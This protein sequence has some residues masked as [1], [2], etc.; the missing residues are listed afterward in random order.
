[1]HA[2]AF[3]WT[4]TLGTGLLDP[5]TMG[6]TALIPAAGVTPAQLP[7]L[8]KRHDATIFAAA[9]GVYRQMLR[10]VVPDLPKLRHGLS[11]GEKLPE[12]THDRWFKATQTKIYEA[13]GMSECSTFVS[14]SPSYPAEI[15]SLG[16]PQTGRRVA[17]LDGLIAKLDAPGILAVS[18]QDPGLMLGYWDKNSQVPIPIQGDWFET[19][20]TMQMA[21]DGSLTYLG[22]SDDMMNAGG[23]RVSP[24]EVE[25]IMS[26]H[27]DI[28]ECAAVEER[29][30]D[31]TSLIA[32]H[33]VANAP[34]SERD[35]K[36]FASKKLGRYKCPRLFYHC[37]SLPRGGNGKLQR[38]ALRLA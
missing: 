16:R 17:V 11:A 19:G 37:Q 12:I 31:D 18:T 38:K 27:P 14:G 23:F 32:L 29:V 30:T 4:Y 13:F 20:D 35:L 9:P 6:A 33:Y 28:M 21:Q 34:V 7:L 26:T 3:N 10:Q 1:M 5:W 15:G 36:D 2:G 25:S 24:L 22:R 8:M